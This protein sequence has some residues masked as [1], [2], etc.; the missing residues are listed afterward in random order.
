MDQAAFSNVGIKM[1]CR[2]LSSEVQSPLGGPEL[3]RKTSSILAALIL[4]QGATRQEYIF[5]ERT[6]LV[7][8]SRV[9]LACGVSTLFPL[10]RQ[11]TQT[12]ISAIIDQ[13]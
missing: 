3:V 1:N 6:L 13:S 4:T 9:G 12:D 2:L 8:H 7:A 11:I 5:S 10:A